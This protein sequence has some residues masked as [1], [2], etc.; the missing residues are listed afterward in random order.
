M[1]ASRRPIGPILLFA[2]IASMATA[3][4]G[5]PADRAIQAERER[6][7][8]QRVRPLL[9]ES[10]YS[11]HSAVKQKGGLRLDSIEAILGGGDSGPALVPGKPGE[12]LL[13][14]AVHYDGPEMPPSGKLAPEKINDLTRW[15]AMG[16]PWPSADR[17]RPHAAGISPEGDRTD[18]QPL[19]WSFR[20]LR[21]PEVPDVD[22]LPSPDGSDWSTNPIDRF[23]RQ[24]LAAKQLEPAPRADR[25]TLIRRLTFDLIGLPPTPE[26][27]DAFLADNRPD[28]YERLVDRLLASPRYGQRWARHWLDLVRY[29]ESD[30]YRQDAYRPDAWRYRDYVVQSFNADKPYDRFLAEQLAGDEIDPDD[31]QLRVAAG[32]LRLWPYEYN[33]RNVIGQW[34]D[35]VN[36]VTDVT[37]EVFL[38][39]SI[40]CARCHDHKFDPILQEDYFRLRAFFSPMLPRDDLPLARASQCETYRQKR[41][42]WEQAAAKILREMEDIARPY[43]DRGTASALAKFQ[44]DIRA[45]LTKNEADRT[46]Y[47]RQIGALAFRQVAYE[48]DQVPRIL[49]GRDKARWAELQAKLK[50]FEAIRPEEPASVM[51]VRDVGPI[52][53]PTT[54]P[55]KPRKGT[56]EPGFPKALDPSPPA[57]ATPPAAPDSTG[58]RL[59]LAQWLGRP[60]HPLTTRVIVNRIWQYHFGRGLSGTPSDFGRLGEPPSHPELL[61]WLATEFIARGQRWK[62]IHRLIVSSEAYRQAAVR[63]FDEV[64]HAA[65]IDPENRLLWKRT[66]VRLDAE[67]IRDAMLAA[68][69]ELDPGIGGPSVSATSP[70]R[71]IETRI[72]RNAPDPMLIAFDAP[73]G[74]VPIPRRVPTTTS[75]QALMLL[76]GPWTL[77]R[78]KSFADRVER[79]APASDGQRPRILAAYRLAIGRPPDASEIEE[80]AGFLDRARRV[81]HPPIRNADHAALVDFGHVLL[82]SNEFLYV[83]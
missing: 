2:T 55:G 82:N 43:R 24:S 65:R 12:S 46:P 52:A 17:T 10:C 48:H 41:S 62:P 6:F 30:G 5:T 78:A 16:A 44:D 68:S 11:C 29:A 72:A 75:T 42:A 15:V 63:P 71:T 21:R 7:F 14:E 57:I 77:A 54:I 69:G 70:R 31:P 38:G 66:V 32:Y 58:R 73:D 49:K 80:A 26:E 64:V 22:A 9:V 1:N 19:P 79:M 13:V 3:G 59:A 33:Q 4:E 37:G 81:S 23:I 28:A 25:L 76:N 60:D 61:D 34:E 50:A 18:P 45:V 56:I 83:D 53:P 27:V 35:I 47:E 20:P 51:T 74:S 40:G 39:L 67:E 8:E 36:D